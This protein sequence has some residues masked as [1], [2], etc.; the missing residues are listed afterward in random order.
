M[1][2]KRRRP[3]HAWCADAEFVVV[4]A[5]LRVRP[6][7][8]DLERNKHAAVCVNHERNPTNSNRDPTAELASAK[9]ERNPAKCERSLL[10]GLRSLLA[11]LRSRL[12]GLRSHLAGLRSLLAGLRSRLA[13]M[14]SLSAGYRSHLAGLRS[15]LAGLRNP[16]KCER[17]HPLARSHTAVDGPARPPSRDRSLARARRRS[18]SASERSAAQPPATTCVCACRCA[19]VARAAS[20]CNCASKPAPMCFG[21]RACVRAR[22]CRALLCVCVY[23]VSAVSQPAYCHAR[24]TPSQHSSRRGPPRSRRCRRGSAIQLIRP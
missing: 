21:T 3:I 16:A 2:A 17:A 23:G 5:A 22:A 10:A 1:G 6:T 20:R 7:P 19:R 9:G 4:S 8:A 24:P 14:R 15:H 12:A 13:G 11:G 18:S